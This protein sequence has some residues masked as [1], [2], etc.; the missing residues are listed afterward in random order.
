MPD[1]FRPRGAER[2]EQVPHQRR[3]GG[4]RAAAPGIEPTEEALGLAAAAASA[5]EQLLDA[6]NRMHGQTVLRPIRLTLPPAFAENWLMPRL[7]AWWRELDATYVRSRAAGRM[8]NVAIVVVVGV[9]R[10][11]RREV[12]GIRV[13]P[14]EAEAFWSEFLRSLT[15]RG[16]RGVQLIVSDAHE[17]LKATASRVLS[18]SWQRCRVHFMRNALSCV[19][20]PAQAMVSAE[21]RTA[22]ELPEL[23]AAHRRWGELVDVFESTHPRLAALMRSAEADVLAYKHFP[24]GHHRQLHSTNPLERLN[25]ARIRGSPR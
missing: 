17:G 16:L 2:L 6:V 20:K 11:G 3:E 23:E 21:L 14:S 7:G 12:L 18:A 22:F 19:P 5:F 8:V 25:K 9:N 1:S 24:S 10:D 4:R 13:M 15:H